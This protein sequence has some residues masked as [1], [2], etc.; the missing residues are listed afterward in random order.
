MI[1][2]DELDHVIDV[3]EDFGPFDAW[4][5]AFGDEFASECA[6]PRASGRPDF[7]RSARGEAVD[8]LLPV[9]DSLCKLREIFRRE[10]P[11]GN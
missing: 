9:E 4:Q 3:V 8:V 1:G 2:A 5:T 6:R 7:H 11:C 10:S